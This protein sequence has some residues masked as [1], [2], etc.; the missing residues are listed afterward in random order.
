LTLT[1]RRR[2]DNL[3]LRWQGRLDSETTDRLAPWI[4][5]SV[6]FVVL[7]LISL[8]QAR[9]LDGSV[10]LAAYTQATWLIRHG[11]D[12]I[13]TVSTGTNVFAQQGAFALW[14]VAQLTRSIPAIP[15]LLTVQSLALA[16]TVVPLWRVSRRLASLRAGA[17]LIV[18]LVFAVDPIV[19]TLNLDGFHPET[20]ALPFLLAAAYLGLTRRW[21]RFALCCVIVMLCRAD[22]GLAVAGL[23]VLL[24]V[25]GDR[26]RGAITA[27]L[28]LAWGLGF[29]FL[30][31][32]HIGHH[33]VTQLSAYSAYGRTPLTVVGGMLSHPVTLWTNVFNRENFQL[34][35]YLFAP[36]L[37]LPFL[38]PRYLL[39]VVPLELVYLAGNVPQA[40]RYGPQAVAITAFIFLATPM[41]LARLARRNVEVEKVTVDRRVLITVLL[42]CLSFYILIA[43]SSPYDQPWQWGGRDAADGARLAAG[44]SVGHEAS[45]RASPSMLMILAKRQRLYPLDSHAIEDAGKGASN[46]TKGVDVVVVDR[47]DQH[48]ATADEQ[49][50]WQD[51]ITDRGFRVKSNDLGIIVYVRDR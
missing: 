12:P 29:L 39:P 44:D 40:A 9:S 22:L 6:L 34:L 3:I 7:T 45:V 16:L 5:A 48:A 38:S 10:D 26:R 50:A 17:A 33:G 24:M 31:Q 11:H 8:A 18:L 32:P 35:V 15:L 46:A 2:V 41:G 30:L 1:F 42:A 25:Q 28:G 49:Q 37:F 14:G 27:F 36:V 43:P 51:T 21:G 13:T 47:R 23:G 4:V 20:I 19:Q